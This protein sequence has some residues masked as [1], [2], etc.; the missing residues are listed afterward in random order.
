MQRTRMCVLILVGLIHLSPFLGVFGNETLSALYGIQFDEPN[1]LLLMRHRAVLFGI[2]AM[3]M[4]YTAFKPALNALGL[5][6]GLLSVV[7]YLTLV[8][9]SSNINDELYKVFWIDVAALMLLSI[10]LLTL[11]FSQNTFSRNLFS[12]NKP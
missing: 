10:G 2:V 11:V 4:I 3:L 12:T 5:I 8:F 1:T 9:S 7:S 6:V